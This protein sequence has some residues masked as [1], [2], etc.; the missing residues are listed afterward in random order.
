[1]LRA[2]NPSS[3]NSIVKDVAATPVFELL[4][5]DFLMT[6]PAI[7]ALDYIRKYIMLE[8]ICQ[9]IAAEAA[10]HCQLLSPGTCGM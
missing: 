6:E 10:L 7:R 8:Y 1:L 4:P 5:N 3:L 2:Y 9:A